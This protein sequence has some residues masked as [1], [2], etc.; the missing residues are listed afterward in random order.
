MPTLIPRWIVAGIGT[1]AAAG[2][3]AAASAPADAAAPTRC[4]LMPKQ[5]PDR[6]HHFCPVGDAF[7]IPVYASPS[8]RDRVGFLNERGLGNWFKFQ[9]SGEEAHRVVAGKVV[10]NVWWAFTQADVSDEPGKP[11]PMGYVPE[12]YF[13]GGGISTTERAI[14][15]PTRR[16]SV[17]R[18]TPR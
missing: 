15:L 8:A 11:A 7:R 2:A 16:P 1:L 18:R 17:Q 9:V 13:R 12:V 10:T 14:G 4:I 5:D 3:F 6:S